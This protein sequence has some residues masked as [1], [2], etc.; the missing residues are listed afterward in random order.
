MPRE[1]MIKCIA[2]TYK[3]PLLRAINKEL[4]EADTFAE[5]SSL[6]RLKDVIET[7][8]NCLRGITF[9][10]EVFPEKDWLKK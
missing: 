7:V 5:I 1:V 8:P 6:N 4:Q 9:H 3:K 2:V 10:T